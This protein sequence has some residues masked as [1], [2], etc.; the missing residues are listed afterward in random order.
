MP[1]FKAATFCAVIL[2]TFYYE[3]ILERCLSVCLRASVCLCF[4]GWVVSAVSHKPVKA[5]LDGASCLGLNDPLTAQRVFVVAWP[6]RGEDDT[7]RP[8]VVSPARSW[9][10]RWAGLCLSDADIEKSREKRRM[11]NREIRRLKAE[12]FCPNMKCTEG[13]IWDES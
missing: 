6:P 7:R 9:R 10:R 1:F 12:D 3:I 4:H 5:N 11:E 13:N 2:N 8:W